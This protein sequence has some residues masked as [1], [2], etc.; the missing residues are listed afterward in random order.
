[1]P[2]SMPDGDVD[3]RRADDRCADDAVAHHDMLMFDIRL[4]FPSRGVRVAA[5]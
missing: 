3:T 1:M 5:Q 4:P 2:M